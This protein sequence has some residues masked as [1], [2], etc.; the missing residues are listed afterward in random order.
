MRIKVIAESEADYNHWL[1]DNASDAVVPKDTLAMRG[2][3]LFQSK[4]CASCH[5]IQGTAASSNVGPDLTHLASRGE[6][7]TGLLKNNESNLFSWVNHPQE[8]KPGAHMPD[9]N[10]S[11]DTVNAIVHY[12]DQLK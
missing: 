6:I 4:T 10:F 2:A 11:K 1:A 9:F 3:E 12:L 5:R 8:I 7:L